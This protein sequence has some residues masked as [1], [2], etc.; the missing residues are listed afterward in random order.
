MTQ[1]TTA[2]HAGIALDGV[3]PV[4]PKL[5]DGFNPRQ[6][7][8]FFGILAA[9][10]FFVAYSLYVDITTTGVRST[11][12][13]PFVL[14]GVALLIALGFEFVNGFHDT[15]NA[16]ATVIYTRRRAPLAGFADCR[17]QPGAVSGAEGDR[18]ATVVDPMHSRPHLHR[19][20]FAHGSNDGQKGMGL[21]ML[22]LIGVVPTAYAL[23][24][25]H[26]ASLKLVSIDSG[27]GCVAPSME[28]VAERRY[29]PLA[30]PMFIYVSEAAA[31]R[32]EARALAHFYLAPENARFALE[33]G[34]LPLPTV[35][36]LAVTRR[37]DKG[38]TGSL[39]GGR[40]S[41]IGVTTDAFQDEDKVK[42]ALV[43]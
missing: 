40:G 19:V 43:R 12:Y 11:N 34:D 3:A 26:R 42:N 5:D 30:R 27:S 15:A 32:P 14:L 37:L 21:I 2:S 17:A 31:R 16:V 4:R 36:L 1:A 38:L 10:L 23:N 24:A 18:P 29:Q 22:I 28:T 20:S 6:A 25:A 41:V 8:V 9:G 35:T 7:L 13:L 39:F 33:V